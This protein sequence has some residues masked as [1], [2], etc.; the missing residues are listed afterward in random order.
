MTKDQAI[1][2]YIILISFLDHF[3]PRPVIMMN[4]YF[5]TSH[6]NPNQA[7]QKYIIKNYKE[8]KTNLC[9]SCT[10]D[11]FLYVKEICELVSSVDWVSAA[12]EMKCSSRPYD[13][14]FKGKLVL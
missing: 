4:Q 2:K 1:Y 3:T 5:L 11:D 8:W 14:Y 7:R 13:V 10:Q 12:S 6:T 9:M